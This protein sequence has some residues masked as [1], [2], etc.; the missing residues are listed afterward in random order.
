MVTLA[1]K[2][3]RLV[4]AF[5]KSFPEG[6]QPSMRDAQ[7]PHL[8]DLLREA[9]PGVSKTNAQKAVQTVSL[10]YR[11]NIDW[12]RFVCMLSANLTGSWMRLANNPGINAST[13]FLL[14]DGTVMVQDEGG[15]TWKRLVPA[16]GSYLNG[17]WLDVAPMGVGRLYYASGML[18][19]G[20]VLVS[21]GEYTSDLHKD[22]D[23]R[24][25]IYDP[26]SDTWTA[27]T[28]PTGWTN[29]GDSP[30]VVLPDGRFFLGLYNGQKTAIYNPATNTWTAGA[31][32]PQESDEESWVLLPDNTV[33]SVRCTTTDRKADKYL[34]DTDEWVDGGTLPQSIIETSSE[35]IGPGL[36]LMDG[37]ALFVGANGK[38]AFYTPPTNRRDPGTW[39]MGPT[40]PTDANGKQL[41]AKDA[42]GVVLTNGK[43]LVA[44]SPVDGNNWLTPTHFY[45][46]N[47]SSFTAAPDPA[48][49]TDVP[50]RGRLMMLPTGEVLFAAATNEIYL[51]SYITCIQDAWRPQVTA[52]PSRVFAGADFTLYG[53]QLTG[54]TQ[55][56]GYGDDSQ[57][58]TNYPIV[59]LHGPDGIRYL[60]TH[61]FSTMAVA[62]GQAIE[63][64]QVHIPL[65]VPSGQYELVVIANGIP[66]AGIPL[67]IEVDNP[68][69][70]RWHQEEAT[71]VH[72]IGSLADGPLWVLGPNGP[73]PVDPW[74]PDL[75][76]KAQEARRQILQ[77]VSQL[78]ELGAKLHLERLRIAKGQ[79]R[80]VDTE[81]AEL[82][83][84]KSKEKEHH[85]T[86]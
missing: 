39:A 66:S 65:S 79:P 82:V 31:N 69:F 44:V 12:K 49:A 9:Y 38:T 4:L 68:L 41:G 76:Q 48:N 80:A 8:V 85:L 43:A 15:S 86:T 7:M 34:I 29:I 1:E 81:G 26:T 19:D 23:A 59:R 3:Q 35:E 21:G 10:Q 27:L 6:F 18:R 53:R 50:Y 16:N 30:G 74:G 36:L 37:R 47:G 28:P 46:C 63:S 2:T 25:E 40:L 11:I 77:G 14:T 20:R 22:W 57:T 17:T 55:C 45:E 24:T 13:M 64:T 61:A 70:G 75:A 60:R 73:V 51:Y 83:S 32:K 52:C 72:L 54:L 78:R 56:V 58:S 67:A 5:E 84:V 71:F 42:P 33:I 62:T